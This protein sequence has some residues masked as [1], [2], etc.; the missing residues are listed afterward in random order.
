[1]AK[2]PNVEQEA[3]R[4]VAVRQPDPPI[5]RELV[6]VEAPGVDTL[7]GKVPERRLRSAEVDG[8]P[9]VQ[10]PRVPA[11]GTVEEPKFVE[12]GVGG[13][14]RVVGRH[15]RN[16]QAPR[17][18]RSSPSENERVD[19]VDQLGSEATQ[20]VADAGVCESKLYL[21]IGRE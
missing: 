4:R 7:P 8:C 5:L 17:V 20:C 9:V 13:Y 14:V 18:E 21:G 16:V 12:D 10:L 1:M 11:R 6:G 3:L 15:K 19:G 2:A